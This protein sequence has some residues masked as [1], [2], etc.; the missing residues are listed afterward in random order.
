MH[1]RYTKKCM[2]HTFKYTQLQ[3]HQGILNTK[4]QKDNCIVFF[5]FTHLTFQRH[6]INT[7]RFSKIFFNLSA[8]RSMSTHCVWYSHCSENLHVVFLKVFFTSVITNILNYLTATNL[9]QDQVLLFSQ[10]MKV[11]SIWLCY[12]R[13][14][15]HGILSMDFISDSS[16]LVQNRW[17]LKSETQRICS[18]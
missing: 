16:A 6:R 10:M 18:N 13:H 12:L 8:K 15:L 7:S 3:K 1:K 5:S 14:S 17:D 4:L 9:R 2:S 11:V